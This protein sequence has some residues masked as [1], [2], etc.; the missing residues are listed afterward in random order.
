MQIRSISKKTLM[1]GLVAIVAISMVGMGALMPYLSN[2]VKTTAEVETNTISLTVR[3]LGGEFTEGTI[4]LEAT[5]PTA[6]P[7]VF[8]IKAEKE[9]PDN[10][11]YEDKDVYGVGWNG[12][13]VVGT[14]HG[15]IYCKDGIS[16]GETYPG[17]KEFESITIKFW[18]GD[19]Y[20][21]TYNW[22]DFTIS[23]VGPNK[24]AIEGPTYILWDQWGYWGEFSVQFSQYASGEYEFSMQVI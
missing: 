14:L 23:R 8:Q 18:D 10:D 3:E 1:I 19:G 15:E 4:S 16:A 21:E 6:P 22:T 2:E 9:A 5:Q 24:I 12:A 7:S 13:Q 17:D 20:E 11:Y